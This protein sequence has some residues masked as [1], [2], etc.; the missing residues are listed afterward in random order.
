MQQ[1]LFG[2]GNISVQR[3][4][5]LLQKE[6]KMPARAAAKKPL[7]TKKMTKNR[8]AFCKKY[9][10]WTPPQW[11]NVMFSDESTFRLVNSRGTK[12]G[13]PRAS[14]ATNSSTPSPL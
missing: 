6:L 12:I 10:R 14:H 13:E 4:H 2:F 8:L 7:L 9:L 11:E 3:I 1:E 5:E